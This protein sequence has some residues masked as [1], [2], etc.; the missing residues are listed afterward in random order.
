MPSDET[1]KIE[2]KI[3]PTLI[4]NDAPSIVSEPPAAKAESESKIEDAK[5]QIAKTEIAKTE[6]T[7]TESTKNEAAPAEVK[8]ESPAIEAIAPE[9]PKAEIKAE[10]L[11][12]APKLEAAK[13]ETLKLETETAAAKSEAITLAPEPQIEPIVIQFKKPEPVAAAAPRST[14]FALLAASVAIAASFGAIGGSI[15]AARL[16][17]LPTPEP[18]AAVAPVAKE[19]VAEEVRALKESVAQLRATTRALSDGFT[20]L[21][22]SVTTATTQNGKVAE[23]LERIEKAQAA[24]AKVALSAPAPSA[25]A[26]VPAHMVS[27]T[28][29][30]P[31]PPTPEVTGT[32][33][34]KGA[35][36]VLG[37]PP[38]TLKPPTVQGFVLRR[39]YDGAALIEGRDGMIEVEPGVVAPGLGRIEAI[40]REDGR[41]VVVTAR[42]IVR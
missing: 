31:V 6:S 24:A 42:G 7:K 5:T 8:A 33:A 9:A 34:P 18:V 11:E 40:K 41:W 32:I 16:G 25:P 13:T 4:V 35:P 21:R 20:T 28:Q 27:T 26:T 12:T 10:A 30:L 37:A 23:T 29:A 19:Q 36:M 1:A 3:E 15:G 14:R 2:P 39:V 22:A 38:S 17:L